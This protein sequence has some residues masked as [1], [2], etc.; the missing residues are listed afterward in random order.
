MKKFIL[1]RLISIRNASAGLWYVIK[2]QKNT[3]IHAIATAFS[4]LFACWLKIPAYAWTVLI[5]TIGMVWMA[6]FINT[7]LEAIVDLASPQNH[8]LAKIGK[9]VG[10]AAVLIAAVSSIVIGAI[11]FGPPLYLK[12]MIGLNYLF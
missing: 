6:E 10:A 2:T 11:I 7:S 8:P 9:D 12:V 1:S 3:W 5:L 4:L